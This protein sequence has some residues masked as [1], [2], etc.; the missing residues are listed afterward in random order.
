MIISVT[1]QKGGVGK[2]TT[3]INL[4]AG[5][6]LKNKKVL[7][8]DLD[9][10]GNATSGL[11]IEKNN[12]GI[13]DVIID[14]EDIKSVIMDTQVQNLKII[15]SNIDLS[16]ATVEMVALKDRESLLKNALNKIKNDFDFIII[17]CPPSLDLLTVNAFTASDKVLV[18]IQCEFYALEGLGQLMNT[19][20][21]IKMRL[22]PQLDIDGVVCTM[23]DSRTNLSQQ[24]VD[25]VKKYF[26]KKVYNTFIPRNVR[27]AEAP[28]FGEP[29]QI[30]DGYC[31]GAL[32]YKNLCEE[33]IERNNK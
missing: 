28:S 11:G 2:T 18:P 31:Q 32:A 16:G 17:D 33:F 24:V 20:K 21:L 22:N 1:N 6:A 12:M 26:A 5:L 13:Y 23:Y 8:L 10:Q 9:P 30:F 19:V 14:N 3:A 27:L 7:L 4:S 25:E 29:I 15:P